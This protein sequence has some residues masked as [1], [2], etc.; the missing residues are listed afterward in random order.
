MKWKL[1]DELAFIAV[2]RMPQKQCEERCDDKTVLITGATS[3]V[4]QA[5]AWH[6]ASMGARLILLVRDV[7]KGKALSTEM[8][9]TH[10]T[11]S[12]V[13]LADFESLDQVKTACDKIRNE[14]DHIDILINNAGVHR[15]KKKILDTGID[16]V[17]TVN[18][19]SP[20]MISQELIPLLRKSDDPRII[21]V[22]SEG[23]RFGKVDLGDLDWKRRRYT[24]LKSYGQSKTAQLHSMYILK[25][26]LEK[27]RI[28]INC[29]HP[30]A[31][32]SRIGREGGPVYGL[33]N[34]YIIQPLLKGP[35]VS[36]RALY[37]HGISQEMNG[38]SGKFYNLTNP[39]PPAPHAQYSE[40]S[41]IIYQKT[42]ELCGYAKG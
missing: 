40:Q 19:L 41:E 10:H 23:H 29:V 9:R 8:G 38:R 7:S 26:V 13:Y 20:F 3:G 18:H 5:T 21:N 25:E 24:G 4:G 37:F 16:A 33:Y 36:A 30:G 17:F 39:E 28:N 11:S 32:K 6:F 1:P 35:E 34:K 27:L 12:E 2:S 42:L 15:T 31:V 22:N 14:I